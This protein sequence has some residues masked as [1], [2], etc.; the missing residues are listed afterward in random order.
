M[1]APKQRRIVLPLIALTLCL[2]LAACDRTSSAQ[3]T[4]TAVAEQ[5]TL[6]PSPSVVP[7]SGETSA[8]TS[9]IEEAQAFILSRLAQQSLP[10]GTIW[11]PSDVT[12]TAQRWTWRELQ[13]TLSVGAGFGAGLNVYEQYEVDPRTLSVPVRVDGN[14]IQF[15]C[16]LAKCISVQK[17]IQTIKTL[18][19][20]IKE[21]TST[22][23]R[24][25]NF[26]Y[27]SS[28]EEATRVAAAMNLAL[29]RYGARV[30]VF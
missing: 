1:T 13:T 29:A 23:Q 19:T 3:S 30:K 24:A 28:E 26:W 4:D 6:A 21:T 20:E 5:S 2:V 27:S 9:T 22:E 12:L 10:K 11:N 14:N 16:A 18:D 15:E 17:S 8:G 7:A 25:S